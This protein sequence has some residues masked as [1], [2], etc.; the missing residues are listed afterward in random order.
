MISRCQVLSEHA[1][2]SQL[3]GSDYHTS[4]SRHVPVMLGE[5]IEHLSPQPG[6]VVVDA[7]VGAGGH[8]REIAERIGSEGLLVGLDRDPS[9]IDL[10]RARVVG[11]K[12]K[13]FEAN[14]ADLRLVLD[15]LGI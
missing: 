9:M 8:S 2:M 5:V 4:E 6:Q 1:P 7:T 11:S 14:F 10:A 13:W 3:E 15:Q 12:T